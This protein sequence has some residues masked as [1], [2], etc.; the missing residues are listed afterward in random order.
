VSPFDT[1]QTTAY[2]PFI[3]TTLLSWTLSETDCSELFLNNFPTPRV[4]GAPNSGDHNGISS[5]SLATENY[6]PYA[7]TRRGLHMLAIFTDH[8]RWPT[9]DRQMD[10]LTQTHSVDTKDGC[11]KMTNKFSGRN[12]K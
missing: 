6:S 9:C 5:R 10:R 8:P 12:W 7:T 11:T 4:F 2:S 1:A 3:K